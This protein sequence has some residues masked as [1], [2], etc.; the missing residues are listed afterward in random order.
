MS[1]VPSRLRSQGSQPC[2]AASL[3]Q[4][5]LPDRESAGGNQGHLEPRLVCRVGL[6][7]VGLGTEAGRGTLCAHDFGSFGHVQLRPVPGRR[8]RATIHRQPGYIRRVLAHSSAY[9]TCAQ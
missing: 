3:R 9:A 1:R 7:L 5:G 4:P 6:P 8:L 2:P